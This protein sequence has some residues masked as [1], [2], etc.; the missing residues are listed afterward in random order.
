MTDEAILSFEGAE[1]P[2]VPGETVLQCLERNGVR[3]PSFCRAGV[4]QSC[5]LKAVEGQPPPKAQLGLRDHWKREGLFLSCVCEVTQ[6]MRLAPSNAVGSYA[7]RVVKTERLS[8]DVVRVL[9]S[10]P[11]GFEFEAG[12]F[13]Q[14]QRA[15]DGLTRPYSVASLP[16]DEHLEFHVQVLPDGQLSPWFE[17]AIDEAVVVQGPFGEC[18]YVPGEPERTLLLAATGTGLAPLVGVLRA[19][20][21]AGHRGKIFLYHGAKTPAHLYFWSELV[22]LANDIES[23]QV[24]GVCLEAAEPMS[25]D[26]RAAV[27]SGDLI[28][29]VVAAHPKPTEH[30]NYLCGNPTLVQA[31][32]KKLY[33]AGATLTRIHSDPFLPPG[34]APA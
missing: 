27:A 15:S 2:A 6:S 33:L 8:V 23:L 7:A 14:L 26:G 34:A 31:L 24:V 10:K 5:M 28:A 19:A 20:I 30:R 9:V 25:V 21:K 32:K 17:N 29:T 3:V 11:A 12:Q 16:T 22:A 13:V 18:S 1:Y 4:C